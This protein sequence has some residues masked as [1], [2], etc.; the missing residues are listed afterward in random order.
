MMGVSKP[1]FSLPLSVRAPFESRLKPV[2][3]HTASPTCSSG[4]QLLLFLLRLAVVLQHTA[5]PNSNLS[6]TLCLFASL[7]PFEGSCAC[8]ARFQATSPL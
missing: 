8:C 6:W 7:L 2:F 3:Q 1:I 4:S 5:S